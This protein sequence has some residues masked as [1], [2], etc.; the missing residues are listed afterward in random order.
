MTSDGKLRERSVVVARELKHAIADN[1][2]PAA[3][4]SADIDNDAIE[5]IAITLRSF[6]EE[7]AALSSDP[8]QGGQHDPHCAAIIGGKCDCGADEAQFIDP[9]P[10]G[11]VAGLETSAKQRATLGEFADKA[12][13]A[14]WRSMVGLAAIWIDAPSVDQWVADT[15]R[16]QGA[17]VYNAEENAAFISGARNLV[18][19]L[20]R[21]FNKLLTR[22]SDTPSRGTP[23]A[24]WREKGETDPHEDRYRGERARLT[25]GQ[26][27]DDE[28]AYKIAMLMH[29]DLDHEGMLHVAR[30]RIRWLSRKLVEATDTPSR[31]VEA[32]IAKAATV[33][34]V[35]WHYSEKKPPK[36]L[37][38]DRDVQALYAAPPNA[39]NAIIERCAEVAERLTTANLVDDKATPKS[40]LA[41]H[42]ANTIRALKTPPP[43]SGEG[44]P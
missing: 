4:G 21:D 23:A 24:L 42:I 27:T 13:A 36:H 43:S 14:P 6:A 1:A 11:E 8:A 35:N 19:A 33:N 38:N 15:H 9:A 12:T 3:D 39:E 10:E 20:L 16:P 18:P 5:L 37:W 2:Y 7:A 28:V 41:Q 31:E 25:G 17:A 40:S 34:E 44:K 29:G 26:F 32:V 22:L 30:D